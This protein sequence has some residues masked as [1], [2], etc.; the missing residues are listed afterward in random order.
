[1]RTELY[2]HNKIAY[3]K[4]IKAFEVGDRTCVVHPTGTGKSYLIAAVSELY[5]KVLILG[6]N[7]FVL[8]QVHD[9]LRWRDSDKSGG[10]VE[11]MTYSSLMTKDELPKGYDMICLDEFHRAGAPEWGDAVVR[12][13][14]ANPQAKVLGTTATPVRYL[15]NNRD[16]SEEIFHGNVASEITIAEAWSR[17]IL[18]IPRYISG[19]FRWDSTLADAKERIERSRSFSQDEKRRRLSQLSNMRLKWELSCGMPVVLKK[20]LDP[21]ARRIIVFCAHIE[22]IEKMVSEVVGWFREAGFRLAGVYVIH[23]QLSEREQRDQMRRFSDSDT[24]GVRLMFSVNMLNEGIHVSGVN[25]VLMLRTTSSRIIYMQQ[26]GRCLTAANSENPL[27]LD[28]VD[29]IT[30]TTAI[31]GVQDEFERLNRENKEGTGCEPRHFEVV[32]YTLDVRQVVEK[33]APLTHKGKRV[34]TFEDHLNVVREYCQKQGCLP[35]RGHC[36]AVAS[37]AWLRKHYSDS[38]EV[39]ELR[40]QYRQIND[41]CEFKTLYV[42]YTLQHHKLPV[43]Q[44]DDVEGRR[45]GGR[46]SYFRSELINDPEIRQLRNFYSVKQR[47]LAERIERIK[48]FCE[49]H[50]RTPLQED[51]KLYKE[52]RALNYGEAKSDLRVLELRRTYQQKVKTRDDKDARIRLKQVFDFLKD[53]NRLPR[54]CGPWVTENETRVYHQLY[55]LQRRGAKNSVEKE[56]LDLA[57]KVK[58]GRK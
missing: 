23:S 51:G 26:M 40:D 48:K 16:M 29:N 52:W 11:Y 21:D 41:V 15:D 25:A 7:I 5:R 44:S 47:N 14:G 53:Q 31:K 50:G 27:V 3:Q 19:L 30:T 43:R 49:E 6:P 42:A 18:P 1:M 10:T 8:D 35:V 55:N 34:I 38:K 24:E 56:L 17:G 46:W 20:H 57:E 4:V 33:L 22:G 37:W 32:D 9:V 12:L 58:A 13:L 54:F 39:A 45:L 28:M 36:E 2:S